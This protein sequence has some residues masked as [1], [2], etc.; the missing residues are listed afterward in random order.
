MKKLYDGIVFDLDGVICSTDEYHYLAWK[1]IADELHT[2][3]DRTINNRL[4][5]VSRQESLE[6]ILERY[7]GPTLSAE[8]KIKLTDKKNRTYQ[9]FLK[10]LTPDSLSDDVKKTLLVF[11]S[12]EIPMAIGSS[13]KNTKLILSQIGLNHF[14]DAV[15]DGN[16]ITHS[17]PNPEVFLKA[18]SAIHIR[19]SKC[20]VV[21]DADAGI[22]AAH[23][24]GFKSAGI[25][26]AS[27][28]PLTTHP[29]KK[30]SDLINIELE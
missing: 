3:F 8:D 14:F 12:K 24:G 2:P 17:K 18:A 28:N 21:E 23:A 15:I 29:I 16:D 22:E 27:K 9:T 11:R 4:R 30:I 13:S 25:S 26:Q 1:S 6:I 19:P 20:L 10:Q 7:D 5:G